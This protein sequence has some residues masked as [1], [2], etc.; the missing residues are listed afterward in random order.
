MV[1]SI[2]KMALCL[3]VSNFFFLRFGAADASIFSVFLLLTAST[4]LVSFSGLWGSSTIFISLD[5]CSVFIRL[6]D[7]SC[8]FLVLL[9][10]SFVISELDLSSWLN[11]TV[12]VP[13]LWVSVSVC[14]VWFLNSFLVNSKRWRSSWI[15]FSVFS[16]FIF[17]SV[18]R[19]SE[20]SAGLFSSPPKCASSPWTP[21]LGFLILMYCVLTTYI[22]FQKWSFFKKNLNC[23]VR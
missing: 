10:S 3:V 18:R 16:V 1:S 5:S 23:C 20:S 9:V 6:V 4:A 11:R 19:S 2:S 12:W 17:I 15:F 13:K 22:Y 21:I 7:V 8:A 14:Y